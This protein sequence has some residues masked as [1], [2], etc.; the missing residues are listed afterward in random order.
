MKNKVLVTFHVLEV[1]ISFDAFI[2]VNEL[3]WKIK[4]LVSKSISDLLNMQE[5]N[6]KDYLLLNK[7]TST[8]YHNNDTIIHTDIRNGTELFLIPIV[9]GGNGFVSLIKN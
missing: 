8:I 7:D 3:V 6:D 9:K 1:G 2:P 5:I 4:K